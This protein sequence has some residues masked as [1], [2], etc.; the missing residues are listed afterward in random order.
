MNTPEPEAAWKRIARYEL[1]RRLAHQLVEAPRAD[2]AADQ[3]SDQSAVPH[4]G[5]QCGMIE[6]FARRVPVVPEAGRLRQSPDVLRRG[7]CESPS[8]VVLDREMTGERSHIGRRVTWIKTHDETLD[9]HAVREPLIR[10]PPRGE[11]RRADPG[12]AGEDECQQER[13][14][15]SDTRQVYSSPGGGRERDVRQR[16]VHE[17]L[18]VGRHKSIAPDVGEHDGRSEQQGRRPRHAVSVRTHL[19]PVSQMYT[20][21]PSSST[22]MKTSDSLA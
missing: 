2:R 19:R 16:H 21:A 22:P 9:G 15:R 5:Q 8:D 18:L 11:K 14:P 6:L 7:D 10:R 20:S 13:P 17:S 12:A 1:A 3:Q 4:R